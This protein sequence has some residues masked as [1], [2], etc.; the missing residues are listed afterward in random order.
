MK[1][2]PSQSGFSLIEVLIALVVLSIGLMGIASMQVVG[3][4]FNQQA[5]TTT[6]AIELA[7]DMADRIRANPNAFIDPTTPGDAY[8]DASFN[9]PGSA[10]PFACA[11]TVG[12]TVTSLN[13]CTKA[14]LAAYDIWQWKTALQASSGSGLA[15]GAGAI[16]HDWNADR[17]FS[18]YTIDVRWSERGEDAHY[19]L[20]VRL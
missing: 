18:T 6:R 17:Q 12:N 3:L 13:D 5:L 7:S 19:V 2:R 20:E 16:T 11:D 14:N 1:T 4:Q 10:A 15:A 8:E 9:A